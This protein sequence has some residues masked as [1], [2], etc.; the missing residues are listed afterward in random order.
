MLRTLLEEN[1]N[2]T[3]FDDVNGCRKGGSVTLSR[4]KTGGIIVIITCSGFALSIKKNLYRETPTQVICDIA[5]AL[6][7]SSDAVRYYERMEALG[8]DMCCNVWS[9]LISLLRQGLL[10]DNYVHLYNMDVLSR[11]FGDSFHISSHKCNLCH[12]DSDSCIF[13]PSLRRF[14]GILKDNK[15]KSKA[16]ANIA[17]HT[18]SNWNKMIFTT[19]LCAEKYDC[20]LHSFLKWIN[21]RNDARLKRKG[22]HFEDIE[23]FRNIRSYKPNLAE[24]VDTV[25]LGNLNFKTEIIKEIIKIKQLTT[26]CRY[27][28]NQRTP[29]NRKKKSERSMPSPLLF[30]NIV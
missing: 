9:R 18:W 29:M 17:E 27:P 15:N 13:Q 6:T 22:Y 1:T 20:V 5:G 7:A 8:W 21:E 10:P 24:S 16:N 3:F 26:V 30:Q 14:R 11:F 2:D 23:C 4:T 19:N 28:I 12:R 25:N